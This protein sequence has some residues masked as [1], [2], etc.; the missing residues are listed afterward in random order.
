[1]RLEDARRC[2]APRAALALGRLERARL[3]GFLFVL[4]LFALCAPKGARAAEPP[5]ERPR[6]FINCT[7]ECYEPYLRQALSYFDVVRDRYLASYEILIA[8]QPHGAGGGS[9]SVSLLTRAPGALAS[10]TL[11]GTRQVTSRFGQPASEVRE[12]LHDAV[13]RLLYAAAQGTPLERAFELRLA[14]R[15]EAELG[16]LD[17]AW[18]YWVFMPELTGAGEGGSGYRFIELTGG[19]TL[20][21]ITDRHK[22]RL[23]ATYHRSF[24]AFEFEDGSSISGGVGGAEMNVVY[25]RSLGD[26]YAVGGTGTVERTPF[27]NLAFHAHYGPVIE[28]SLFPY[29]EN[30]WRQ[31]RFV[32]QIGVWYN[33]YDE[34]N[35]SGLDSELL[36]YHALSTIADFNQ[37]WGS[38]QL[39]GQLNSFVRDPSLYR[40]S[41]GGRLSL[42]LSEGLSL[43]LEGEAALVRDQVTARQRAL[44]DR[45]VLL[46]T[47]E[48]PTRFTFAATLGFSYA[49]GSVHNTIVNPRFGRV[50][51]LEE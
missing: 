6:L 26:H 2:G 31:L 7:T 20:R 8:M 1:M 40:F 3:T 36:Y 41:L 35:K 46:F 33:D 47:A 16:E 18:D 51:L 5:A 11:Q 37:A 34:P 12:L 10:A 30:A 25:A 17:D 13:L 24:S 19:V 22:L 9:Y 43:E 29:K 15:T 27:E 48:Q 32:Y 38:L 28:A 21:R 50:D 45:E 39:A 49:F 44:E 42:L 14:P 23:R 4:A